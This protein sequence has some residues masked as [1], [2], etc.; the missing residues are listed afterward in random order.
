[1]AASQ[2]QKRIGFVFI[3]GIADW[4]F[5]FLSGLGHRLVRRADRCADAGQRSG[6][7]DWRLHA[8]RPARPRPR[9]TSQDLDAVAVIGSDTWASQSADVAPLLQAVAGARRRGRRHLRRYAGAGARRPVPAI[10]RTPATAATGSCSTCPAT[11]ALEPTSDVPHAVADGSL[12]CA[13]G[14]APGTFAVEFLHGAVPEKA[15]KLAEM[16]ILFAREHRGE[17]LLTE[18]CQ[19]GCDDR[20]WRQPRQEDAQMANVTPR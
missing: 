5:G 20:S 2:D 17:S 6:R 7:I 10:A 4:E 16:R 8:E 19:E 18:G 15:G 3:E 12:V 9:R 1:M 13:P 14:S 11:P